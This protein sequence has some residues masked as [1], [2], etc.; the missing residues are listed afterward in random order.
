[1]P[2]RQAT[3]TPR[4][5]CVAKKMSPASL[6]PRPEAPHHTLITTLDPDRGGRSHRADECPMSSPP[7]FSIDVPECTTPVDNF[8]DMDNTAVNL[9]HTGTSEAL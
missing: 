1:M 8:S 6:A 9:V 4:R 5:R 3:G 2:K 7:D